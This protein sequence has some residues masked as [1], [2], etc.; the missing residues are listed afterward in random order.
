MTET[1]QKVLGA[2][3]QKNVLTTTEIAKMIGVPRSTTRDAVAALVADRKVEDWGI[4]CN[5]ARA[6]ALFGY[7]PAWRRS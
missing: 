2:F 3:E 1:Q 4:A 5:N 7:V 6:Y